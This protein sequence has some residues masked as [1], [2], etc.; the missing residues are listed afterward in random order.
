MDTKAIFVTSL[1]KC[2]FFFREADRIALALRDAAGLALKYC[3]A[4]WAIFFF[5][6]AHITKV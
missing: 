5:V 4:T 2:P 1:Y 3:L 6:F